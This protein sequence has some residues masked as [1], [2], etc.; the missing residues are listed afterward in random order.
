[1]AEHVK[2]FWA[3]HAAWIISFVIVPLLPAAQSLV[4][5]HPKVAVALGGLATIIAKLTK[6][7]NY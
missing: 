1:M 2:K 7:P 4:S 6:S 3:V 5:G